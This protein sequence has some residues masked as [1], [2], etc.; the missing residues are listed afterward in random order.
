MTR[1][2]LYYKM[3]LKKIGFHDEVVKAVAPSVVGPEDWDRVGPRIIKE[4]K[5]DKIAQ[6]VMAKAPRRF[7]KSVA[8]GMIV[9]AYAQV[10]GGSVQSIFSTGRRASRNLL[11]IAYKLA[12]ERGLGSRIVRYNQEELWFMND[13]GTTSKIFS[14]PANAKISES[15]SNILLSCIH[16]S[17]RNPLLFSICQRRS[18]PS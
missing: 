17:K 3:L 4:R 14:Y 8:V 7:G 5:W 15:I 18:S 11:D 13:D 9:I 1:Q 16:I 2:I 10:M 6:M 12:L